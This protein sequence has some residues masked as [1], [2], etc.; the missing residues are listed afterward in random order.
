MDNSHQGLRVHVGRLLAAYVQ[1]DH[2]V[3]VFGLL[4][5]ARVAGGIAST[6]DIIEAKEAQRGEERRVIPAVYLQS[7][8][9]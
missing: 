9:D 8:P 7:L 3:L 1:L 4:L 2:E 6:D 5:H